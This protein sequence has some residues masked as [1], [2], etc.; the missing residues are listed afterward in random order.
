MVADQIPY[1][2]SS[3][4]AHAT[5]VSVGFLK[6]SKQQNNLCSYPELAGYS[7]S[8]TGVRVCID[9]LVSVLWWKDWLLWKE[10]WYQRCVYPGFTDNNNNNR[11]Q[12]VASSFVTNI[13][14]IRHGVLSLSHSLRILSRFAISF[15]RPKWGLISDGKC[16]KHREVFF[17]AANFKGIYQKGIK[18]LS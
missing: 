11:E 5:C 16:L 13:Q 8:Y 14:N 3:V 18:L 2:C 12:K 10:A 6:T 17:A 4:F 9:R 1:K 15:K 7:R